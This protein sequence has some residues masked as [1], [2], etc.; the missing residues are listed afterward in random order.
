MLPDQAILDIESGKHSPSLKTLALYCLR[1]GTTVEAVV[2]AAT[3]P[4]S[5]PN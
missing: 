2:L 1:L 4:D 5:P 3:R